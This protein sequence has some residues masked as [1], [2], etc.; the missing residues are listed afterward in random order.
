MALL[1]VNPL[2]IQR[3]FLLK[4]LEI[5]DQILQLKGQ[6]DH[7]LVLMLSILR[8]ESFVEVL[9]ALD[10]ALEVLNLVPYTADRFSIETR[11]QRHSKNLTESAHRTAFFRCLRSSL[12]HGT[13]G[14]SR[15]CP[16]SQRAHGGSTRLS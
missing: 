8:V 6:A 15:I 3:P 12:C 16:R 14:G 2:I 13:S 7:N 9:L 5:R 1:F 11:H 4:R 10:I